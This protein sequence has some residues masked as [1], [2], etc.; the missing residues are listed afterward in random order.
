MAPRRW[1]QRFEK[2]DGSLTAVWPTHRYEYEQAQSLQASTSP[3]V[4]EDYLYDQR[5]S[6]P[7]IKA[8]AREQVRFMDV[9]DEDDID[10]DID[11][12]KSILSWGLGKI[13][14]VGANG[15]ERWAWGRP[16]EMP[17]LS[18]NVEMYRFQP[19]IMVFERSSDFYGVE[20]DQSF[21]VANPST[22]EVTNGGNARAYD[23]IIILKGPYTNPSVTNNSALMEGTS[24]AYKVESTTDG[25]AGTDWLKFDSRRNEIMK[26]TNSG[27][28]WVDDSANYVRQDGQLRQMVIEPGVNSIVVAGVTG[29]VE[30]E[31]TEA[32]H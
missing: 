17:Q 1:F 9:N 24:T 12:F 8:N 30:I 19:V 4:G 29:D 20:H 23:A 3:L 28:T 27:G 22:I 10:E 16:V 14:T 25:A 2:A 32:W 5:G 21:D 26:S 7:A 31:F 18:F 11:N 13:V 15:T 6:L